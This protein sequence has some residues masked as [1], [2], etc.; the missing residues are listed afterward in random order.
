MKLSAKAF[1]TGLPGW[2]YSQATPRASVQPSTAFEV[3][4]VPL[5]VTIAAGGPR[6]A[7]IASS[8]L[9]TRAPEIEVSGISARH[10]RVQSSTTVITRKRRPPVIWSCTKSIDQRAFGTSG[11]AIGARL[12]NARFRPPLRR[13]WSFSST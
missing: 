2:M 12:P 5:S 4:S 13:T 7:M 10:S 8:S 1:C 11:T 6:R 3:N 9:T